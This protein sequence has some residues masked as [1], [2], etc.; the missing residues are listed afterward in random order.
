VTWRVG[1]KVGR[2]IYRQ[3]GDQPS[4]DDPLIGVMDT[5]EDAFLVVSA[6]N[7]RAEVWDEGYARGVRDEAG[8]MEPADNPYRP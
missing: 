1:R 2:T 3:L 4:D 6:V 7:G 8:E 5:P